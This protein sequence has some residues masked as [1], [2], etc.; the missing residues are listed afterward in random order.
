MPLSFFRDS[1]TVVRAPLVMKNGMQVRDWANATTHT[2]SRVQVAGAS[3]TR[4]F[5]RTLNVEDKRL[6]RAAYNADI[7]AGD[8]VVWE[9]ETYEVDGEVLRTKSPTGRV[10]SCRTNLKRWDG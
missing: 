3:T 4:D 5:D 7:Q 9:G 1:I 8:R 10:S 6:L 2:V